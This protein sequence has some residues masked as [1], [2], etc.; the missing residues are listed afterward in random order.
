MVLNDIPE[1]YRA[2]VDELLVP[3]LRRKNVP[4]LG[5]IAS[6]PIMSALKVS[7]FAERLAGKVISAHH[8]ADRV[9]ENFLIGTMQV[10]NFLAHFVRHKNSAIIVW[11]RQVDV[12][13]VALEA[14]VLVSSLPE[15]C[16]PTTS[17]SPGPRCSRRDH[18]GSRGHF[19]VAKKMGIS[20]PGTSC[21]T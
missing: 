13:L 18:H 21:A 15:I 7:D 12:Q 1:H 4:V 17:F 2:E 20:C 10:E 16:T 3:F 14:A 19:S 5:V 11:R 8:K 6:D 9:V